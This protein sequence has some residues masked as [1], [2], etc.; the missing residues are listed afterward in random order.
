MPD[1]DTN[2]LQELFTRV[3]RRRLDRN[4]IAKQLCSMTYQSAFN[5]GAYTFQIP[6]ATTSFDIQTQIGTGFNRLQAV[7]N[8]ADLGMNW[9]AWTPDQYSRGA[10]RFSSLDELQ[11]PMPLMMAEADRFAYTMGN[12]IDQYIFNTMHTSIAASSA[13]T[14]RYQE[15]ALGGS[16]T[17]NTRVPGSSVLATAQATGI[18]LLHGLRQL[19]ATFA[20]NDAALT[21]G[22][23]SGVWAVFH[24]SMISDIEAAFVNTDNTW[25][26]IGSDTQ[27]NGFRGRLM[28]IDI[29]VS[30]NV[31]RITTGSGRSQFTSG[32]HCPVGLTA[33]TE[34]V[35]RVFRNNYISA[36]E[37]QVD[38]SAARFLYGI[39]YGAYVVQTQHLR[40]IRLAQAVRS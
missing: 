28:G 20:V 25:E 13:N 21:P 11:T 2:R 4:L 31:P 14:Q 32:Y 36:S 1:L 33:G 35:S 9:Q 6:R 18:N 17:G 37:N 12:T 38:W 26:M 8:I 30:N 29:F 27:R 23:P 7:D 39:Y 5:N 34:F 3:L 22:A 24:P 19:K 10:L 40:G 16:G 15:V